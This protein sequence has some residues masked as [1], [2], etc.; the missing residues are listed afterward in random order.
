MSH[1]IP[2]ASKPADRDQPGLAVK[3]AYAFAAAFLGA[4]AMGYIPNPLV[5]PNAVFVT[6]G[7]HNMV[8]LLT[9]IAFLAVA[10]F[11]ETASTRFMFAFGA[12]YCAVGVL[13]FAVLGGAAE[14]HLLGLVH[15]NLA[16]NFLHMGLGIAIFASGVFARRYAQTAQA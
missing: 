1:D 13:G 15:I 11:G 12:V 8:H 9:A 16:D 2:A 6:N 5:G 7:A 14:T 10:R 3:L 4:T